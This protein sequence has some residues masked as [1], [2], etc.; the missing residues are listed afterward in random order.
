MPLPLSRRAVLAAASAAM[1]GLTGCATS[2][3]S[4][5]EAFQ[6]AVEYS[7][8]YNEAHSYAWNILKISGLARESGP[9]SDIYIDDEKY[10]ELKE[11]VGHKNFSGPSH[12][13]DILIGS[14][15]S[16]AGL[17]S[18]NFTGFS[19]LSALTAPSPKNNP[20]Y[21]GYLPKAEA[22]TPQEA[23]RKINM[24]LLKAYEKAARDLGFDKTGISG[25]PPV[26]KASRASTDASLE[27]MITGGLAVKPEFQKLTGD[28]AWL[29][30]T[31]AWLDKN[32]SETWSFGSFV[33]YVAP[34]LGKFEVSD[35]GKLSPNKSID[36]KLQLLEKMTQNL[37]D[38]FFVYVPGYRG[39]GL[40]DKKDTPPF[41]ASN[42]GRFFFVMP[43]S[44]Q[45]DK[46]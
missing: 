24:I 1:L 15:L 26:L 30:K 16:S 17:L 21:I 3:D 8:T 25:I 46:N 4:S 35:E 33:T 23:V 22:A 34:H 32:E 44:A 27:I 2:P 5:P 19:L 18:W 28:P 40:T 20:M 12:G 38:N 37:P 39:V 41:I 45:K 9:Y 6:K 7:K 10:E 36:L 13:S 43:K 14:A 42:K 11:K 29:T 31:P